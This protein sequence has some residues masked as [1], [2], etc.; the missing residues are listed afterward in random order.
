[1]FTDRHTLFLPWPFGFWVTFI[2]PFLR[3]SADFFFPARDCFII[4]RKVILKKQK[5][6][7]NIPAA[8]AADKIRPVPASQGW[9]HPGGHGGRSDSRFQ[10]SWGWCSRTPSGV[11]IFK[12]AGCWCWTFLASHPII[13]PVPGRL[14]TQNPPALTTWPSPMSSIMGT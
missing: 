6:L 12:G 3:M 10:S 1:M 13:T 2:S 11:L 4:R 9:L 7:P 8:G 14:T 5:L